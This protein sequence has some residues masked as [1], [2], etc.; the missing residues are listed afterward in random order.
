MLGT[1]A[2]SASPTRGMCVHMYGCCCVYSCAW[3]HVHVDACAH[4]DK[5]GGMVVKSIMCMSIY[6]VISMNGSLIGCGWSF[7]P[8]F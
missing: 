4:H 6:R 5:V 8:L 2:L 1:D 3:V 7:S